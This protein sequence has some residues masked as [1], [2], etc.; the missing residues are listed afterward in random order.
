MVVAD[1]STIAKYKDIPSYACLGASGAISGIVMSKVIIA[2]AM[3][4][5]FAIFGI[6][7]GWVFALLFLTY[8]YIAA[9]RMMDNVAHEAHLWGALAGIGFTFLL[10]PHQSWEFIEM[11]HHTFLGVYRTIRG[12]A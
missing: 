7:P 12:E 2:P 6:I 11:L 5:S 4:Q 1:F 3:H 10:F 8:S 9:R